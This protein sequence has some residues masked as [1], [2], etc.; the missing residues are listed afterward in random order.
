MFVVLEVDGA[1]RVHHT[2]DGAF[3][4]RW[5][6]ERQARLRNQTRPSPARWWVAREVG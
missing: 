5:T 1:G 2:M 4:D 6:A 3:D